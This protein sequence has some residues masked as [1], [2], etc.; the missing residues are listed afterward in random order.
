MEKGHKVFWFCGLGIALSLELLEFRGNSDM[1]GVLS[2]GNNT[3]ESTT[4]VFFFLKI[5][6]AVN[7]ILKT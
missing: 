2:S 3:Q 6:T 1:N 5:K 4:R 7:C